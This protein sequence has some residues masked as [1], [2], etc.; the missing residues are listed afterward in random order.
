MR[1][2]KLDLNLLQVE[3]FEIAAG[4]RGSTVRAHEGSE[5][6]FVGDTNCG[7]CQPG[8]WG[9]TCQVFGCPGSPNC[10]AVC[11]AWG[12]TDAETCQ[13]CATYNCGWGCTQQ[14]TCGFDCTRAYPCEL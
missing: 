4:R 1:K 3:S 8:S 11:T 10:T 7:T 5:E 13:T 6:T 9:G 2:L 14:D 12:C